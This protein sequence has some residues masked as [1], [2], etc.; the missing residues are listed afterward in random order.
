MGCRAS[1]G[2]CRLWRGEMAAAASTM[3][4]MA[5]GRTTRLRSAAAAEATASAAG[6]GGGGGDGAGTG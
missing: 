5:T 1:H 6:G 4:P 2:G 3:P